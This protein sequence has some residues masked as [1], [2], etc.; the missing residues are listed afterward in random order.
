MIQGA[1]PS[2][3]C[4]VEKSVTNSRNSKDSHDG[5][6]WRVCSNDDVSNEFACRRENGNSAPATKAMQTVTE[7][8]GEGVAG[9]R[10]EEDKG[11][12]GVG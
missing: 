12:D 8:S 3:P 6:I 4:C 11:G 2:I 10:R 9:E 7:E 5:G 1:N